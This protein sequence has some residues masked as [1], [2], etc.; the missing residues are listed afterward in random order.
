MQ[1]RIRSPIACLAGALLL[2]IAAM[3]PANAGQTPAPD[4]RGWITRMNKALIEGNFEG[5]FEQRSGDQRETYRIVHRFKDG[6]MRERLVATDGSGEE[7]RRVGTQWLQYLPD[8]RLMFFAT[9]N[10]SFGYIQAINGL[11]DL[12]ARQYEISEAGRGRL[13]GREVQIIRVEPKDNLRFG[14]RFWLDVGSALPL[15]LQRVAYDGK[16][17][18]EVS[19]TFIN[20]PLLPT[21]ISDEQLKVAVDPKGKGYTFVNLD[22]NTPF[23]NPR[24]KRTFA[25][26]AELMP[27]GYRAR[28]FGGQVQE[29]G[30][31]GPRARFVVSDGVS[32]GEVFLVPVVGTPEPDGGG[33]M[34]SF[35]HYGV[36]LEGV[37]IFVS[38]EMPLAAAQSIAQ[39]F[40]PE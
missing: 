22:K 7:Q 33:T 34:R 37:R 18:K 35:A 20:A 19:F 29:G 28:R 17:I 12:T 38:G 8:K 23:Y 3:A 14:Y 24:L 6:E 2:S 25:P 36:T 5:V 40:R 10:R 4:A 39:A 16:V 27:A 31:A 26:Q 11:D 9:R 15:R 13:L 32:W 21:D 30:A 1:P